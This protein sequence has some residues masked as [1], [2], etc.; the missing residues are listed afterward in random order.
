MI[1]LISFWPP[2]N[3][4][5]APLIWN[6]WLRPCHFHSQHVIT[7]LVLPLSDDKTSRSLTTALADD[8]EEGHCR[9]TSPEFLA[10][11]LAGIPAQR[12]SPCKVNQHDD[13]QST[14]HEHHSRLHYGRSGER[15]HSRQLVWRCSSLH[16]AGRRS[17]C[18]A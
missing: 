18:P 8:K 2:P 11:D 13:S 5:L 17:P 12:R 7:H 6:S 15:H 10:G 9:E 3:G 14:F 16:G 4:C 1:L